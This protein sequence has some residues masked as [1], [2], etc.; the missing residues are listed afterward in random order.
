MKKNKTAIII[1]AVV[2]FVAIAV[3]SGFGAYFLFG[4]TEEK[5]STVTAVAEDFVEDTLLLERVARH[6]ERYTNNLIN[7]YEMGEKK[8]AEF[9][10]CPE[11]WLVYGQS[12]TVFNNTADSIRVYGFEIDNNGKNGVYIS[13]S[14]GGELDIAPGGNGPASFSVFCD[15]GDLTTDEAKELVSNFKIKVLYTKTPT[16]FDDGTESVE[17]TMKAALEFA[18]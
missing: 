8:A 4:N 5:N 11:E 17:E 9:Y 18:E 7:E 16:E 12:I 10:E 1:A 2:A 14:A 13:T 6:P 3:A 15:N